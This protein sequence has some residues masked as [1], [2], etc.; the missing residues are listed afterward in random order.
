MLMARPKR[1]ADDHGSSP[2]T[3]VCGRAAGIFLSESNHRTSERKAARRSVS[4]NERGQCDQTRNE[5]D[6]GQVVEAVGSFLPAAICV[7]RVLLPHNVELRLL[8]V[9]Q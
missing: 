6:D 1:G 5:I 2:V 9:A 4:D 8:L 7:P 3:A